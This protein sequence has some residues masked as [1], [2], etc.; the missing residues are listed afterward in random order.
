[1]AASLDSRLAPSGADAVPIRLVAA[2]EWPEMAG[3]L[4]AVPRAF[5]EASGFEA[6]PGAHI[7]LPAPDGRLAAVLFG[8]EPASSPGRDPFELGKLAAA[9][10][11][12]DYR[13]E[14]QPGDAANALLAW[15]LAGYQFDRYRERPPKAVRLVPPP[16]VDADD[17]LR[18]AEA[19]AMGRDLINTP[20]NDLGPEELEQ[21]ARQLAR[22]H[23]ADVVVTTGDDLL[24]AN[25]PMIHAVG[26]ASPRPPRLI[27]ITWGETSAPAVTF[28]GKGVCF[29]TGGLDIKPASAM[30]LM[31]KD[32]GGAAAALALADMTMGAGL[33]LRLRVL[34][35]AVDN[36][37]SGASFRPGDVLRARNGLTVQIDNT[38][39]EGRLVLADALAL[40]DEEAPELIVDFA[41][42]TGAARV[43]LGPDLPALYTEDDVLAADLTRLGLE[44]NDPVWRMP[45][46][47]PYR[48][49]VEGKIA[50]LTNAPSGGFAGSI[51]AALFLSR[52]V[53]AARAYA[54]LDIYAWTPSPRPA[55]PEGGEVQ[56]ARLLYALLREHYGSRGGQAATGG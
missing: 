27:D 38:D 40:A 35:P 8:C 54:H 17:V 50:A 51:T 2:R 3:R 15:L 32:M 12:G 53:S 46:W 16:G 11:P 25:L 24:A 22:R 7:L 49:M 9:L 45:L 39:A 20:A 43:A 19:A 31:K 4:D 36:A 29:D 23:G 56:G 26:R 52:F 28:V 18:V 44:V 34:V 5:A 21:A 37:I 42:L 1:M 41:T 48:K 33:P 47:P 13:L 30:A 14:G 55:R 6:K 10:P